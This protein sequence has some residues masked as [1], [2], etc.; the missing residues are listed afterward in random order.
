VS[1][2]P[3]L[4]AGRLLLNSLVAALVVAGAFWANV[5]SATSFRT[6]ALSGQA[7][8][9]T[10]AGVQFSTLA[11]PAL[12]DDGRTAF[13][14]T[15][16][17]DGV[18]NSNNR[19]IWSEGTGS[20]LL[21]ARAGNQPPS[22]T[23][24][25]VFNDFA[26]PLLNNAGQTAFWGSFSGGVGVWSEGSGSLQLV[27]RN[28][29]DI[30]DPL[31]DNF[32]SFDE[33]LFNDAGNV[34]IWAFLLP[35]NLAILTEQSGG[36]VASAHSG[37]T[38]PAFPDHTFGFVS[39]PVFND[40]G[41][42]A[43]SVP[44]RL[45][46]SRGS[47]VPGSQREVLFSGEP[48][49]L[50]VVVEAGHSAP[51]TPDGVIFN[52][53]S[54]RPAINNAG[55]VA[56]TGVISGTGVSSGNNSGIWSEATGELALVARRGF[57]A[58][59]VSGGINFASF[60]APLLN[61]LGQTAFVATISGNGVNSS[62]NQGI[63]FEQDGTLTLIARRGSPAP[64]DEHES[65]SAVAPLFDTLEDPALNSIGQ[66]AFRA[67]L[68]GDGVDASNNHGI[69]ATDPHGVLQPIVRAGDELEV[70][71]GDFRTVS[72]V[73]FAANTGGSDG[74]RSG[75]NNL[76]QLGFRAVFTDNSQG[77]FVSNLVAIPEPTSLTLL[78]AWL[79]VWLAGRRRTR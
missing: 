79:P 24:D 35:N 21:V 3:P 52:G 47:V 33:V 28:S 7:A 27:V 61:D 54:G 36:I 53:F 9:G 63:W 16:L 22:E 25:G 67:T 6:V 23:I 8:P 30:Y 41:Q 74:R 5:S 38:V 4:C 26:L 44:V 72:Q 78:M 59:S 39:R 18:D 11:F 56:F 65:G 66:I 68:S 57:Q 46:D 13:R 69:W 49:D 73:F 31:G 58:P 77:I 75:F 45:V 17:G 43:F 37:T 12:N 10:P 1:V 51:G 34:A 64:Y 60:N 32:S 20:L 70:S 42:T 29:P 48:N 55:H 62:N 40:V 19:G 2:I 14:A 71:P 76:G 50:R 15:L